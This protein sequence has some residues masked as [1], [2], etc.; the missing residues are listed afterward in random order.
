MGTGGLLLAYSAVNAISQVQEG[1]AQKAEANLNATIVEG[2]SGLVQVQKETEYEQYQRLKGKTG[3]TSMASI[4]GMGIMP[5]GS[6]MA[7][8]LDT[9]K[10]IA[11]DQSIGQFNY[12][13]EKR[14]IMAEA[15][16][17]RRQGRAAARSGWSNAFSTML[18]GVSNYA[19]Y[20]G[21]GTAKP[22]MGG[23]GISQYGNSYGANT[24][25]S[26]FD[27]GSYSAIRAGRI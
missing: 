8:M 4:A 10:Q 2:K 15:E 13:M 6:A 3:A 21:W 17:I 5:S 24:P 27:M 12:E 16:A 20:K 9:Q 1:Y 7:V 19:M 11:L 14:S 18:S 25:K 26:T 23:G 22:D